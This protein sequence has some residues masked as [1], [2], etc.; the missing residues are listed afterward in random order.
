MVVS[1]N[2]LAWEIPKLQGGSLEERSSDPVKSRT[3]VYIR[4]SD[5]RPEAKHPGEE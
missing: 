3:R 1:H 4:R 2:V 5:K